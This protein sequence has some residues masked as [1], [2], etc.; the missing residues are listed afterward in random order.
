MV[1]ILKN[2][3]RDKRVVDLV[4]DTLKLCETL[5]FELEDHLL[6]KLPSKSFWRILYAKKY[7]HVDCSD[8]QYEHVLVL[9]KG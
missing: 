2:F 1:L 3:I 9:K 7:P 4:G 5:G 8:L 6:F